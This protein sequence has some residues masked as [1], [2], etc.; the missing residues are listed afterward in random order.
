MCDSQHKSRKGTPPNPSHENPKKKLQKSPKGKT[1]GDKRT[2]DEPCQ[3]FYK[4]HERFIQ[5]LA[6]RPNI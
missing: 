3:I 1:L 4:Y 2:H 6:S 5:G